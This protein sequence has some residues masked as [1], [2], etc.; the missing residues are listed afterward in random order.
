M[1]LSYRSSLSEFPTVVM[2]NV[3]LFTVA[4]YECVYVQINFKL[5]RAIVKL[6]LRRLTAK[7]HRVPSIV[8]FG[9]VG[10]F[11]SCIFYERTSLTSKIKTNATPMTEIRAGREQY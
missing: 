3:L 6:N 9:A 2:Q 10:F 1:I 5:E 8:N 7:I 4:S 11:I